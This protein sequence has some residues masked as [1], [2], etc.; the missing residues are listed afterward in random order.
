MA[1]D[2]NKDA[3]K[4]KQSL[5]TAPIIEQIPDPLPIVKQPSGELREDI[6]RDGSIQVGNPN[7]TG[8]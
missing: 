8:K 2:T 5:D 3:S 7:N 1:K 4:N 6:N